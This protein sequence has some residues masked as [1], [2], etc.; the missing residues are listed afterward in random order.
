ML[1]DKNRNIVLLYN[2][3]TYNIVDANNLVLPSISKE[4]HYYQDLWNC[5]YHTIGIKE[6]KNSRLRMQFM[7]KKYW[8]DLVEKF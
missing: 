5:F 8:Q 3:K 7:P 2:T 6:R 1:H 4:E